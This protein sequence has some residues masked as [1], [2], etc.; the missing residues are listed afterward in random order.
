MKTMGHLKS[1]IILED[2]MI[3]FEQKIEEG[4]SQGWEI[5]AAEVRWVNHHWRIGITFTK[6]YDVDEDQ[7]ELPW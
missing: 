1:F 5:D 6:E 4:L 7:E 2:A 3:F